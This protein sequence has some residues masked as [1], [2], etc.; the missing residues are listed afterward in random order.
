[1]NRTRSNGF[2]IEKR[3]NLNQKQDTPL[4]EWIE[5]IVVAEMGNAFLLT[6]NPIKQR[7]LSLI[8]PIH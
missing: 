3:T 8:L 4:A 6:G 5:S 7:M 2:P 1:M